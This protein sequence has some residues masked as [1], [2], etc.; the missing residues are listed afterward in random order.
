MMIL[1]F[2]EI[3]GSVQSMP[4]L[5]CFLDIQ[6]KR[7]IGLKTHKSKWKTKDSRAGIDHY[8]EGRERAEDPG[9]GSEALCT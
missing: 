6:V 3:M 4:C 9:S 1:C 8:G 7:D 5:I 2:T